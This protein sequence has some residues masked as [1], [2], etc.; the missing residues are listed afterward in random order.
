M[1]W[2][3]AIENWHRIHYDQ[4][5]AVDHD[6]LPGLL[7]NGSF[8]QHLLVSLLRGW[9]EPAGWLAKVQMS[10]RGMDLVGDTLT[11]AGACGNL[12][13]RDGLG[14]VVCE[15]GIRNQR[16][17]EGTTGQRDRRAAAARRAPG[18]LPV[19]GT[20]AVMTKPNPARSTASSCSRSATASPARSRRDCSAISEPTWSSSSPRAATSCAGSAHLRTTRRA[21]ARAPCSSSSTGTS[22]A[23]RSTFTRR[24]RGSAHARSRATPTS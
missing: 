8:K 6:G 4:P 1:R 3:A 7:V 15:I 9:L 19:P 16:G 2:S 12:R 20:A 17:E 18:A 11:A 10:F 13:V 24:A 5:F 23:S 14:L 21:S 22:A